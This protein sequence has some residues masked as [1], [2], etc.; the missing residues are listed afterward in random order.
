MENKINKLNKKKAFYLALSTLVAIALWIFVDVAGNAD[1]TP[2]IWSKEFKDIPIEYLSEDTVLADRGLMLLE[3][4]TS[5]TVDVTL[6]GTHW[7][8]AKVDRDDIQVTAQLNSI[9]KTGKQRINVT[10]SFA[11]LGMSQQVTLGEIR[12]GYMATVNIGELNSKTVD[13]RYEIVGNVA[14]GYSAGEVEL[15]PSSFVIR[16]QQDAI[17]A[18][19]YAKVILD[20]GE[21]AHST[22]NQSLSYQFYDSE[23][24]LLDDRDIHTDVESI[25]AR[26][27]V[28]VTKELDL[29]MRF[30]ESA[31]ARLSNVT[32]KIEPEHITV[33]GDADSLRGV[34][35]LVLDEFQLV[36]LLGSGSVIYNYS[37]PIPEGCENLSGIS[38]ATLR[39]SFKDM[40]S[41]Q[42]TTNRL[43]FENLSA[44]G[45]H[46]DILTREV[47]VQIFGTHADVAA[48]AGDDILVVAD[49]SD[50]G[51]AAG[52]YTVPAKILVEGGR[53][54]G[55]SGTYQVRVDIS[56]PSEE[57]P[58]PPQEELPTEPEEQ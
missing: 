12:P 15:S 13:V 32:Y 40:T 11:E 54:I 45:K 47:S 33:T 1:G 55:V 16:G 25:Q 34:D 44:E 9:T 20:I 50:F 8:L 7:S 35:T 28:N 58:T 37:I 43:R 21:D 4:D 23:D 22:V 10:V 56:E 38:R 57:E 49:L 18:V 53:D 46:V 42:V 41:A 26:L 27:P 5:T 52:T 17:E 30:V 2:R 51:G 6:K 39:V 36:S 14:E 48:I 29:T 24:Q 19:S 3:E 31:G